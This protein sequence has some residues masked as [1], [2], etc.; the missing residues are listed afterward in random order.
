MYVIYIYIYKETNKLN[1]KSILFKK[2]ECTY[3]ENFYGTKFGIVFEIFKYFQGV[4]SFVGL[5]KT[6]CNRLKNPSYN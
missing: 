3:M 5:F 1:K 6:E 4:L 2:I